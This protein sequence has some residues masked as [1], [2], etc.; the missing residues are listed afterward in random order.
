MK[1][2]TATAIS[3]FVLAVASAHAQQT[4]ATSASGAAP[5]ATRSGSQPS[6]QGPAAPPWPMVGAPVTACAQRA[7]D[8]IAARQVPARRLGRAA[9]DRGG[10]ACPLVAAT[11]ADPGRIR[12][13]QQ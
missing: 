12:A 4:G 8:V 13:P 1:L 3:L 5:T 11:A 10:H 9:P 7:R 2:L 6:Q